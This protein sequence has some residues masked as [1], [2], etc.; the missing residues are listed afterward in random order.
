[1]HAAISFQSDLEHESEM[2]PRSHAITGLAEMPCQVDL[3][4]NR[5]RFLIALRIIAR[6]WSIALARDTVGSRSGVANIVYGIT[7]PKP[8]LNA[9]VEPQKPNGGTSDAQQD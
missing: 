3:I 8:R 1:M 4:G 5:P 6:M 7:S 2:Q 9:P